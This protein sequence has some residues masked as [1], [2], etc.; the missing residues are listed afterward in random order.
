[1]LPQQI[2][3]DDPARD[4]GDTSKG[5][6]TRSAAAKTKPQAAASKADAPL[7]RKRVIDSEDESD[8][9]GRPS[10]EEKTTASPP[11]K[12]A[13]LKTYK[14]KAKTA[15]TDPS[16]PPGVNFDELPKSKKPPP[17]KVTVKPKTLAKAEKGQGAAKREPPKPRPINKKDDKKAKAPVKEVKPIDDVSHDIVE[18]GRTLAEASDVMPTRPTNTTAKSTVEHPSSPRKIAKPKKA[19]WED[20]DIFCPRSEDIV[21]EKIMEFSPLR[22]LDVDPLSY[23]DSDHTKLS[24]LGDKYVDFTVPLQQV[25]SSTDTDA[26]MGDTTVVDP[27][28]TSSP[29]LALFQSSPAPKQQLYVEPAEVSLKPPVLRDTSIERNYGNTKTV[30]RPR[31]FKADK[32]ERRP[33]TGR[34][35]RLTDCTNLHR[36]VDPLPPSPVQIR[37]PAEPIIPAPVNVPSHILLPQQITVS[38]EHEKGSGRVEQSRISY[39]DQSEYTIQKGKATRF[40]EHQNIREA[41]NE[42]S[43]SRPPT[44]YVFEET[45]GSLS[46]VNVPIP[47][48][49]TRSKPC[50]RAV[51]DDADE[52]DAYFINKGTTS[53]GPSNNHESSSRVAHDLGSPTNSHPGR[54]HG[55]HKL[56]ARD[57][58]DDEF[59]RPYLKPTHRDL[60]KQS[61]MKT[62]VTAFKRRELD[63]ER[64]AHDSRNF[65]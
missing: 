48:Q 12:K 26:N 41:T 21:P 18:E 54:R 59:E 47:P 36:D 19:P 52:Y 50:G 63:V 58:D 9:G 3:K 29:K 42:S 51:A 37:R 7:K 5:R 6:T 40:M 49:I 65:S 28:Q 62:V 22:R 23:D 25:S 60:K 1:M 55:D 43:I 13:H 24:M 2:W 56:R 27:E 16:S 39:A 20:M 53:A 57:Y 38:K 11:A 64:G 14:K 30:D 31:S 10:F 33:S 8:T 15:P 17:K 61:N 32:P 4:K 45:T 46:P 35:E 44:K 34:Q